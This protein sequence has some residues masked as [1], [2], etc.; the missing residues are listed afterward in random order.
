MFKFL[1]QSYHKNYEL[2]AIIILLGL[3]IIKSNKVSAFNTSHNSDTVYQKADT[4]IQNNKTSL[5]LLGFTYGNNSS[6]LG[7]FQNARLPYISTDITYRH[8]SGLWISALAFDIQNSTTFIDEI[9]LLGGW[10]FDLSKKIDGSIYYSRYFIKPES[11][12]IKASVAN[13]INGYVGFDYNILYSRLT[14]AHIFGETSDFFMIMDHSRYLE[15]EKVFHKEDYFSVEPKISMI[16]G[17]QSFVE[18]HLIRNTSPVSSPVITPKGPG[19]PSGSTTD[20]QSEETIVKKFNV[21]SYEISIPISYTF[22]KFTIEVSGRY[23]IPV[24]LAEGDTSSPQI[25]ITTGLMYA[26]Y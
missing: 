10:N 20:N 11:E 2:W 13:A 25:F 17:T 22:K 9:D 12:L 6:Y 4:I 3:L 19:R 14:V 5:L 15:W 18:S 1:L 26:V 24:N 8:K 21:I 7:R 16:L 23:S